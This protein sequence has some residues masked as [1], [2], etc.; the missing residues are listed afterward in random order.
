MVNFIN[1]DTG[2]TYS[3]SED[4]IPEPGYR[5]VDPTLDKVRSPKTYETSEVIN[6]AIRLG[7]EEGVSHLARWLFAKPGVLA[8][9]STY[10]D[11]VK[12]AR[13]MLKT[14]AGGGKPKTREEAFAILK[15]DPAWSDKTDEE[16]NAAL[17]A[18][19]GS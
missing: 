12:E 9:D 11:A 15:N 19:W 13:K 4:S 1:P 3:G 7:G 6:E 10:E 2:E 18:R 5:R 16:I 17:D 14:S 8:S